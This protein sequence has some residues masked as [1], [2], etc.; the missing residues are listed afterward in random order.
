M[1]VES[2]SEQATSFS[3]PRYCLWRRLRR[4]PL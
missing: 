2:E 1:R 4:K 3:C